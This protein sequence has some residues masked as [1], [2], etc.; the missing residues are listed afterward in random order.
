VIATVTS[1]NAAGSG[2]VTVWPSGVVRPE[3]STLNPNGAGDARANLVFMPIGADGRLSL[4]TSTAS[5]LLVDVV[6]WFTNSS[7]RSSSAGL[8]QAVQPSRVVDTRTTSRQNANTIAQY[9]FR[10][11]V[12]PN[13][14]AIAYNLTATDTA[15]SGYLTAFGSSETSVPLASN[16]NAT[17]ANQSR[18]AQVVT[19]GTAVAAGAGG[20][21]IKVYSSMSTHVL[22]DVAG[23]FLG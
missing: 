23:F 22:I 8:F 9:G 1:V 21:S 16:V 2:Y 10:D 13:A 4:Y 6:G 20:P 12:A 5:D 11:R 19:R 7:A 3:A 17:A 15:A 14:A 18:A